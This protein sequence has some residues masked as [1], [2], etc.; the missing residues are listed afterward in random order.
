MASAR[1]SSS[2]CCS[3]SLDQPQRPS[4]APRKVS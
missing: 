3:W 1:R 2:A 4:A